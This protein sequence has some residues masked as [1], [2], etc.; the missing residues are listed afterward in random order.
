MGRLLFIPPIVFS[1]IDEKF[2]PYIAYI[3]A[4]IA[5]DIFD[6][7]I[8]R[9]FGAET[10]TRRALDG[11]VDKLSIHLVALVVCLGTPMAAVFWLIMLG[12][13]LI[14]ATVGLYVLRSRRIIAAGA[15]W[16]RSFTLSVAAWGIGLVLIGAASWPLGV[17]MSILGIA[18]LI[19]YCAQCFKLLR[20][21]PRAVVRSDL[22]D[23]LD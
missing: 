6:G 22:I 10:A 21:P 9:R 20:M 13:D 19:D 17:L 15:K 23:T 4:F 14:Q 1:A 7:V 16:H 18:T 2:V 12:R 8:A 11:I 5:I 3:A